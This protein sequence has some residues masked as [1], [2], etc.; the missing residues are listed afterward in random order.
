MNKSK[1][2]IVTAIMFIL[3]VVLAADVVAVIPNALPWILAVFALPGAWLFVKVLY[4]WLT[5]EDKPIQIRLPR[6][7]KHSVDWTKVWSG[8]PEREKR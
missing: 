6:H 4:L 8:V 7:K 3:L 5:T 1:A 2:V